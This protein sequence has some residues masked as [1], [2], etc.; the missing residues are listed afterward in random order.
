MCISERMAAWPSLLPRSTGSSG[1]VSRSNSSG[2]NSTYRW[3]F[4]LPR[5]T[6]YAP[7]TAPAAMCP[8][9]QFQAKEF[10]NRRRQVHPPTGV[11]HS[12]GPDQDP[13]Y[14]VGYQ[15]VPDRSSTF[16]K[17]SLHQDNP[18]GWM[19][20]RQWSGRRNLMLPARRG[21]GQQ[22]GRAWYKDRRRLHRPTVF[23][24]RRGFA[25]RL[26]STRFVFQPG[27]AGADPC[28]GATWHHRLHTADRGQTTPSGL[29][30]EARGALTSAIFG[31]V[32]DPDTKA[33]GIIKKAFGGAAIIA[34]SDLEGLITNQNEAGEALLATASE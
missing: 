8:A 10:R 9:S 25:L 11:R 16:P 7:E 28:S 18:H 4:H 19:Y 5:R 27:D 33:G 15:Y 29:P 12:P 30:E 26:P 1:S 22:N 21:S 2:A 31:I 3:Y 6:I 24:F 32:S 20:N 17:D 23:P 34:G 13:Q 14:S